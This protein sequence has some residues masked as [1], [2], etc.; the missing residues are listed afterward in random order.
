MRLAGIRH[1]YGYGYTASQR[2]W[3]NSGPFLG[4]AVR[5]GE[6]FDQANAYAAA[7]G[8]TRL[9]E[10]SVRIDPAARRRVLD[11]LRHHPRPFL[12]LGVGAHGPVRQWGATRFA[13]L[14]KLQGKTEGGTILVLGASHEAALVGQVVQES[15]SARVHPV[16]GWPL[17]DIVALL[18]EADAF[19]GND[20]GLM[21]LRAA[22]GRPAYGLFGAS[23]PL[24]H[25]RLIVPVVPPGGARA[26]MAAITV[27]SVTGALRARSAG[28]D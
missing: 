13:Q 24:R 10:P 21:N 8:F 20:S 14:A 1:R 5:F 23:G 15:G 6:A 17:P 9:P 28:P 18:G 26:G 7:L 25:S 19:V 12:A 11:R 3:L 16:I 27:E 4:G 22:C 2:C